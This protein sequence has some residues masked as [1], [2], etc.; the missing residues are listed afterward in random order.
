MEKELR[1]RPLGTSQGLGGP[2]RSHT[3]PPARGDWNGV[4]T[5]PLPARLRPGLSD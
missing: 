1:G 4:P 2:A 5:G 3:A